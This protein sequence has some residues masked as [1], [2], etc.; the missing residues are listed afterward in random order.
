M[1]APYSLNKDQIIKELTTHADNGLAEQEAR[2]RLTEFGPN[3]L[4]EQGRKSAFVILFNQLKELMV[5][6]LLAAAGISFFLHEYIDAAVILVIVVLN[7]LI[8]FWQEFK[9]ENAM[10]ALKKLAVPNVRVR[11]SGEEKT[12]SAKEL[13]PGD[14]VILEAGNIIPADARIVELS[15]LKVQE[16]AL[17]GESVPVEKKTEALPDAK[18]PLADR[19]NML[20]MGTVVTYGRARAVVTATGISTELGSIAQMLQTVKEDQT[21]LQKRLAK[22]G[23][24]LSAMAVVLILVV[25]GM[26]LLQQYGLKETFMTAI[27]MAVAAIPEGLPAV[28]TIALALGAQRML[29]KKSLIR[30]LAAVETLGSVTL[31]CSDKTGTLTQNKMTVTEIMLPEARFTIE[32]MLQPNH[33]DNSHG[34]LLLLAGAL[35]NDAVISKNE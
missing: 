32:D 3:E 17:T 25:A 4:V 20:Y 23:V 35:C 19:N 30:N 7:T 31:I 1:N 21:P 8:G 12:I 28:V 26:S 6:I 15:N 33:S 24:Q 34:S 9:A 5:L 29:K 22:L 11:R 13:V 10:A 27:S 18:I 14:L 2:K 16:A